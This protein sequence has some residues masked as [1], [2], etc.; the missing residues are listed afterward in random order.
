MDGPPGGEIRAVPV[1]FATV[2][3]APT[4]GQPGKRSPFTAPNLS[5][6]RQRTAVANW[7]NVSTRMVSL[8]SAA[9]TLGDEVLVSSSAVTSVVDGA[10]LVPS[11][12]GGAAP[13]TRQC[14]GSRQMPWRR[15]IRPG[16]TLRLASARRGCAGRRK[17]RRTRPPFTIRWRARFFRPA[18]KPV[19]PDQLGAVATPGLRQVEE[20]L[21][22]AG[23]TAVFST[24]ARR[25]PRSGGVDSHWLPGRRAQPRTTGGRDAVPDRCC[26]RDRLRRPA[27]AEDR[28]V[29]DHLGRC[30]RR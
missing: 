14:P 12:P 4:T 21:C 28:P 8:S 5:W 30:H 10:R 1:G 7:E 26:W 9:A 27:G 17:P 25:P 2:I 11:H 20:H 29:A 16:S 18:I 13:R 15:P 19:V 24:P 23:C 3:V 22:A 6:C